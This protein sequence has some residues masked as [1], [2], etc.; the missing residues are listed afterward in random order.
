[1]TQPDGENRRLWQFHGG[2]HLPDHKALSNTAPL[3]ALP[4]RLILPLQQN[5]GDPA[6]ALVQV[7][8]RVLKGQMTARARGYVSMP[9][10][11]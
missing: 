1:V 9:L 2:L 8:V 11:A 5:I 4:G 3:S 10:Q 6:E 7:G